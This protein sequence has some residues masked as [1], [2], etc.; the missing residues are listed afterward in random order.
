LLAG[1]VLVYTL[2][3]RTQLPSRGD[4]LESLTAQLRA[5]LH[6]DADL[7]LAWCWAHPDR[8]PAPPADTAVAATLPESVCAAL[9]ALRGT[10]KAGGVAPEDLQDAA[11]ALLQ[12]FEEQGYEWQTIER[13]T[14]Y[15][16]GLAHAFDQ[17]ALIGVGQPVET[18]QPALLRRGEVIKRGLLRRVRA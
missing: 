2:R 4:C 6:H 9:T 17:F 14:P 11:N 13:G 1:S 8:A 12:R 15:A 7:I 16:E 3:P 10:L 18:L 5:L